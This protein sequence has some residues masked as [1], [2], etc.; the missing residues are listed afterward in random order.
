MVQVLGLVFALVGA[1]ALA[2]GLF[3]H[4]EPSAP[5]FARSPAQYAHDAA[6]GVVGATMLSAG[7]LLQMLPY[8]GISHYTRHWVA[9]AF[10]A[11]AL[12]VVALIAFVAY[13]LL[14]IAFHAVE[15]R[16]V[17]A[18]HPSIGYDVRR[19]RDGIRFWHQELVVGPEDS[20]AVTPAAP[21]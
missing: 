10:A 15:A 1:V 7:F 17:A 6:F 2:L 9:A 14:Y 16:R 11:V 4:A 18:A 20:T 12:A 19:R 21:S 13:G 3:S 8:L 5:G